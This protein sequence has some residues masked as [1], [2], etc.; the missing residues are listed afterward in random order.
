MVS[1]FA[2]IP[3][4]IVRTDFR[5]AGDS[6]WRP[7]VE[8]DEQFFSSN[9]NLTHSQHG[10]LQGFLKE[11]KTSWEASSALAQHIARNLLLEMKEAL[12]APQVLPNSHRE[13]VFDWLK[14]MPG[15]KDFEGAAALI[16]A[17]V[18]GRRRRESSTPP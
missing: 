17:A 3:S 12:C 4:V 13:I 16:D 5:N 2:D 1:K 14:R 10:S 7:A 6:A 15:F 18:V 8:F 9:R 11:G